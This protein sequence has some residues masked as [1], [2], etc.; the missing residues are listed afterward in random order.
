MKLSAIQQ[1]C[2]GAKRIE[3]YTPDDGVQWIGDGGALYPLYDLPRLEGENVFTMFDIPENKRNKISLWEYGELPQNLYAGDVDEAESL[4]EQGNISVNL[5]GRSLLPLK[6]SLGAVYINQKYLIPFKDSE[7]GV[8]LYERTTKG[9]KVYIAVKEGFL[10]T[11]IILPYDTITQ[12]FIEEL[13]E[14]CELS[15]VALENKGNARGGIYGTCQE[16]ILYQ[17]KIDFD[18]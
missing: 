4:V 16:G 15:R 3:F 17:K 9:G 14:L 12:G 7:N 6:T 18:E 2:K 1:I 13:E 5:N 10:L 11:G 8:Q